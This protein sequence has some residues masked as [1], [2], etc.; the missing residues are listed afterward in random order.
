[1]EWEWHI[2]FVPEIDKTQESNAGW[3]AAHGL[4]EFFLHP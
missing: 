3:G 1:M 4:G 2:G